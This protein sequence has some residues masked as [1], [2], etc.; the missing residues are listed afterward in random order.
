MAEQLGQAT[1]KGSLM[2]FTPATINAHSAVA[3][4]IVAVQGMVISTDFLDSR[5]RS[6][7]TVHPAATISH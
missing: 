1:V 7:C 3:V 5:D 4:A 6:R 2:V